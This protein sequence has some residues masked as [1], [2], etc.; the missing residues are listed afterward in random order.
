MRLV[1]GHCMAL[2]GVRK[3]MG[4]GVAITFNIEQAEQS[5]NS[6]IQHLRYPDPTIT[7]HPPIIHHKLSTY[8][9]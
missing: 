6:A 7:V 4:L 3:G 1:P 2:D 5:T 8:A 9:A